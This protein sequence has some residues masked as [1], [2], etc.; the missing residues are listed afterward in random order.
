MRIV[1]QEKRL[2][3]C[4]M[5]EHE[6]QTVCVNEE[7]T[8]KDISIK[9]EATYYYCDRAQE[10]YA[11]ES[12]MR[13]NSVALRDAYRK[14]Q[15]LLTSKDIIAIRKK[16]GI[17]Q[18]DFC[19]LLGWGGKTITRYESTQIQ[20]KA[21]DTILKKID[22]DPVWFLELLDDSRKMISTELYLKYYNAAMGLHEKRQKFYL[23]DTF[24]AKYASISKRPI[25]QGNTTLQ[26][27]KIVDMIRYFAMSEYVTNLYKVKLMKLMWYADN[28]SY[29]KRG[30]AISGLAY[31]AL[32]M[33]AVP[34][35]HDLITC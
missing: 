11:D 5:E 29:K 21:H 31:Q 15:R 12:Q 14:E 4:C 25:F 17:S 22:N 30:K 3:V 8:Y 26:L 9:Y 20:D 23:Q 1:S 33:G 35:G 28:L 2:C 18:G 32:P 34:I 7:T 27:D 24:S 10:F 6:V 16:Y 13:K 19:I